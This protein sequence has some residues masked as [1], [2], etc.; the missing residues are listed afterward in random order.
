[1]VCVHCSGKTQVINSR[2]QKRLN[3]IWRRRQ[4]LDCGSVF[5][6]EEVP[7][8]SREWL[9]KASD[10]S[11]RPF[12]RDKLMMSLHRSCAHRLTALTDAAA[13]T[14]TVIKKMQDKHVNGLI[15]SK[16]IA[17]ISSVVLN[18]FD[19]A[20]SVHYNAFHQ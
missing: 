9:V 10:G 16:T 6:T 14:D 12:L 19:Q 3:N 18:R 20:A 13:L 15:D 1:M 7:Q 2:H 5:S 11:L 8:Y 17:N 4:C